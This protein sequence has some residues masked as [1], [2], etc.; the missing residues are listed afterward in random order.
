MKFSR[1]FHLTKFKPPGNRNLPTVIIRKIKTRILTAG[2]TALPKPWRRGEERSGGAKASLSSIEGMERERAK[3]MKGDIENGQGR[4]RPST[5]AKQQPSRSAAISSSTRTSEDD[6]SFW[7]IILSL[8][9]LLVSLMLYNEVVR[10]YNHRQQ[11]YWDDHYLKAV[12]SD[13]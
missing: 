9:L 2:E 12:R 7:N 4:R 10:H 6:D 1:L 13:R 3:E 8:L 5:P 11:Q